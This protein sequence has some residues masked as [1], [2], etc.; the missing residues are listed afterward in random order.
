MYN[1]DSYDQADLNKIDERLIYY[2]WLADTATTSH[3]S[4]CFEAF[5]SFKL[6]NEAK[7]TGVGNTF[8]Q[9]KG[10]D[11][12]KIESQ[13]DG[14]KFIIELND[15]LYIPSNKQNLFSLGHWYTAG[16]QYVGRKGQIT[17]ITKDGK[18]V[19]K[20]K[21]ISNNLYKMDLNPKRQ[22]KLIQ[23]M[24]EIIVL[25]HMLQ[26]SQYKAGNLSIDV[27]C[28]LFWNSTNGY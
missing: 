8:A 13:I 1:Y 2:D 15:V 3:V 18:R 25:N 28:W 17:L 19:A 22:M 10:R 4:N 11:T 7:V 27:S 24:M 21:K 9:V 12:I 23:T 5:R 20:G 14:Q 26:L 6:L 16:S